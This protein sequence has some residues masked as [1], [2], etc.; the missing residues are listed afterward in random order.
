MTQI[1]DAATLP[2]GTGANLIGVTSGGQ[3]VRVPVA[4]FIG[5]PGLAATVEVGTVT[6]LPPGSQAT[7]TNTGTENAAV[8]NIG[9]PAGTQGSPGLA[10]TVGIGTVTT[11]PAGSPA[12]IVNAGTANAAVLNIGIPQ[13]IKGDGG[14]AA[15]IAV[16]TVTTLPAGSSASVENVGTSTEAVLNIAI[17]RGADGEGAGDMTVATYGPGGTGKVQTALVAESVPLA[18]VTGLQTALDAKLDDSQATTTGLSVLG[19]A[20]AATARAAIGAGTSNFSGAYGDLSE[21][22]TL[23]TEY[24][25]ERELVVALSDESTVIAVGTNKLTM[26]APYGMTL[27][28]I[29]RASL[30]TASSSGPVTVDVNVAGATLL[31]AAKLSIDATEKTSTTAATP[32][33]LAT[34]AIADDAEIT[35]DIDAGGTGAKGLKVTLYYM[36]AA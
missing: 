3:A 16:G 8:L 22:P 27:S 5:S 9:I 18:G 19:A 1:V 12:T 25:I 23:L 4:Q 29:P 13:G 6:T 14:S 31:G 17:P 21:L 11:L 32:T 24:G 35:F 30:S 10:G 34:T 7:V 2:L 15:T 33:T 28:R 36:R 26:R 20:D